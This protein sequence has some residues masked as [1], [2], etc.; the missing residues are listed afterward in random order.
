[1]TQNQPPLAA[2]ENDERRRL[3]DGALIGVARDDLWPVVE[4]VG[5]VPSRTADPA[6][7]RRALEADGA[8][9]L[10]GCE[11][12]PDAIVVAAAA[13]LGARLRHLS[14]VRPVTTAQSEALALHTDGALISYEIGGRQRRLRDLDEDYALLLCVRQSSSGGESVVADGYRLVDRICTH[15]RTVE[16]GA[17]LT[18]VDVDYLAHAL[19]RQTYRGTENCRKGSRLVGFRSR[20]PFEVAAPDEARPHVHPPSCVL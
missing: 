20:T 11:P 3:P 6:A 14:P 7:A 1:M 9:I 12:V 4:P 13:L 18:G 2:T 17:F 15:P 8:V 16:L 19:W 5:F 10:T